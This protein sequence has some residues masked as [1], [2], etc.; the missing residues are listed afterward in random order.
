MKQTIKRLSPALYRY[1]VSVYF[2]NRSMKLLRFP[3]RVRNLLT[4]KR[5]GNI[6]SI[7]IRSDFGFFAVMQVYLYILLHCDRNNLTPIVRFSGKNYSCEERN[8]NWFE[9]YFFSTIPAPAETRKL[10]TSV[11]MNVHD[12]GLRERYG[13]AITLETASALL[14][15]HM[16]VRK[17]ILSE[18]EEFTREAFRGETLGVHYRGTDKASEAPRV[19]WSTVRSEVLS[20]LEKARTIK[21]IFLASDEPEFIDFFVGSSWPVK[22]VQYD[23]AEIYRGGMPTHKTTG[24]GYRKGKEALITCLLLSRCD[25]CLKT[26]S[27]LSGW[28]KLFNPKL[29]VIMLNRPHGHA[30]WFPDSE[31]WEHQYKFAADQEAVAVDGRNVA[32]GAI[33]GSPVHV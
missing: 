30:N 25:Y 11:I 15:K 18:V 21:T 16:G 27:Y 5:N 26:S 1:L 33:D 9:N 14:A 23:C 20:L 28:S 29:K 4:Q 3:F 2:S 31:I 8:G 13:R 32:S 17:E 19:D 10:H 22:V 7:D 6:F 12:L 24:D